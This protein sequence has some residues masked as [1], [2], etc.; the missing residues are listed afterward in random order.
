MIVLGLITCAGSALAA[1]FNEVEPNDS[2]ST[3]TPVVGMTSGDTIIGTTTGTSTS[4]STTTIVPNSADYFRIKTAAAAL[5]IYRHQLGLASTPSGHTA[6]LRGL[7]Q[8]AGTIGTTD[9]TVQTGSAITNPARAVVWYGFGKQEEIYYRATG[10]ASTSLP[11][12]A[13]LTDTVILPA[14][15]GATLQPGTIEIRTAGVGTFAGVDTDFWLYDVNFNAIPAAGNDDE[16]GTSNVS[17]KMIRNLAP[18]TYTLAIGQWQFANN[19]PAPIDDNYRSGF[20]LDFP[21]A[22]VDNVVN[23]SGPTSTGTFNVLI[24]D[25]VNPLATIPLTFAANTVGDVK[26]LQFSVIAAAGA[27]GIGSASPNP[28]G[29]GGSTVLTIAVTPAPSSNLG[30]VTQVTAD[31]SALTGNAS[32]DNVILV[33]SGATANWLSSSISLPNALPIGLKNIPFIITD[34]ITGP[35][36]GSFSV[37]VIVPPPAN[38]TCDTATAVSAGSPAATG[39]NSLAT[40]GT[41]ETPVCQ[42]SSSKGVWFSFT[43]GVAGNY[44]FNTESSAQVDTVLALYDSC[45]GA[46]LA[47]DDDAGTGTLSALTANLAANQNI[48]VMLSSFGVAATGG[49]YTLN[50]VAPTPTSPTG[51]GTATPASINNG[52][53]TN[54]TLRVTVTPGQVPTSTGTTV[55]VATAALGLGTINLR[56]DGVAPDLTANDN[57]FSGT[58]LVP[59]LRAAA[60]Y[61]LAFNIL[62]AQARTGNGIIA[63]AI[64]DAIGACCLANGT[65]CVVVSAIA[66]NTQGGS[67]SGAA[68]TC[69]TP[70]TYTLSTSGD[71]FE[72][73]SATGTALVPS[74][75]GDLDEG[76]QSVPLGF[77][78]SV[79]GTPHTTGFVSTNGFVSFDAGFEAFLNGTIP[80]AATPNAAIYGLWDDLDARTQGSIKYQTLGTPGTDARFIAQWTNVPQY[81]TVGSSNTFQIVLFE[82]GNVQLRY[83]TIDAENAS[84]DYTIGIEN[85]AGTA[86]VSTPG[87]GLGTGSRTLTLTAIAAGPTCVPT[88]PPCVAD[89]AG[90]A[91]GG[92]DGIVDG[93]DFIAFINAFG[94]SDPL[95]DVAG[96]ANGGPDGI[97]DGSD[98]IAFIN[99]FGA[100]C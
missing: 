45:G 46:L 67:F 6:T 29:Q 72:D 65:S 84:G 5:G 17:G 53:A 86:A 61:P 35:S 28:V 51:V 85:Q 19:Q 66:C 14:V 9:T 96:G 63:F 21:N 2:K 57:I 54:V 83:G 8:S 49:G 42:T 31:V 95:A 25:G 15:S 12:T 78:A 16:F 30:N 75:M 38:D 11:Y 41:G 36:S 58:M 62:D 87:A 71:A 48:K 50:I 97:V 44:V 20:V 74:G 13:T 1:P 39:N 3:A 80:S 76:F 64:T 98:F 27:T 99:A 55:T 33:R 79:Y 93:S 10:T 94:A 77:T 89:V 52:A 4:A 24:S 7:S 81:I 90:G 59:A 40:T 56:D 69:T 32:P 88:L 92:P 26:F 73:I 18:G 60:S 70:A 43:A 91:N 37:T 82:N 34:S 68:T 47:C 100:G 23:P 22:V